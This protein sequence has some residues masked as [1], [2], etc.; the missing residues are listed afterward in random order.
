MRA[1][2]PLA[3]GVTGMRN[4]A[5]QTANI[6]SAVVWA[7]LMLMPGS[8]GGWVAQRLGT[9]LSAAVLAALAVVAIIVWLGHSHIRPLVSFAV[10]R[11]RIRG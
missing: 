8:V 7:P 3:A 1:V 11:S 4:L 9:Q 6:L 2:T 10:T 5:F